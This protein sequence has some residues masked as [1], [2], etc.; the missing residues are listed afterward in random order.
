MP[1]DRPSLYLID[2]SSYIYRAFHA[3]PPLTSPRGVPTQAVYGFTTMLLKLLNDVEATYLAVIFDAPGKTFRD[4]LYDQYKANRAPAPD[5]LKAQIPMIHDVVDAFRICNIAEPG[6]EADDVIATLV[7]RHAEDM[8]CVIVTG[9]KDLMQLVRPS[10]RLW[11]TMRDRW[12]DENAVREKFGVAPAQVV[13]VMALMGDSI[14]NIPGVKGVGAK[15]ASALIEHFGD[16][17]SLL[18]RL[19]EVPELGLRGAKK[20]AERLRDEADKARISRELVVLDSNVDLEVD[21]EEMKVGEPDMDALRKIFTDLGFQSLIDQVA[22]T[23]PAPA[24]EVVEVAAA[25]EARRR[26]SD[27]FGRGAPVAVAALVGDGP[28]IST[29]ADQLLLFDGSASA[30]A[31]ALDRVDVAE[32]L[33]EILSESRARIVG[34]D[35][36]RM[37]HALALRGIDLPEASFDIMVASYVVDPTAAHGLEAIVSQHIGGAVSGYG[38][39]VD[40]T[41]SVLGQILEVEKSLRKQLADAEL[42]GLFADLET[43]LIGVLSRIEARGLTLDVDRLGDMGREFAGRLES[44]MEEIHAI[45]GHPFNINSPPQLRTVLFDE[46]GLSTRGV[47][48][49]K[50]GFSTDVDVLTRLAADHPLPAKILQYRALSKLK[51]TYI[52]ALPQAVNPVTGRLHTTL[53]QTVAATGRISSSDPNL[54]NIPIRGE[55]G[56]RIREAFTAPPGRVLIAGDYSQIEL[57]VLAHLSGDSVLREAFL[58]GQDIHTRTAAEVFGV[59]PGIVTSEMR[60]SAKVINFGILYGMGPQRLARD[61]GISLGEAK[62]YIESYFERYAGV[63]TFMDAVLEQA[64]ETGF[65]TTILGRRRPVPELLSGQRGVAQAAERVATNTPIQG[66]A[67]D[68][69]K[70]AMLHV[71]QRLTRSELDAFM[72]LQV[73]DELLVESSEKDLDQVIELVREEMGRAIELSVPLEV[74]VGSGATWAEAH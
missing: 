27:L 1:V 22:R 74:E 40:T 19:D 24:V 7:R 42:T 39:S 11:D 55:E 60:R 62:R 41:A 59:L 23:A 5:E 8:D 20:V 4:D 46:L 28:V 70:L 16:V 34:Y 49:G 21:L 56:R 6:V 48:K 66:S 57:R 2:G 73:H 38:E 9:D 67:A 72:I 50:T 15:T 68:I 45:A 44:L 64:R 26:L 35:L 58:E 3:L 36:K 47:K 53:H 14:D 30:V 17:E 65:V 63:R 32:T 52:D 33:A 61:L 37:G 29:A 18:A 25:D 69:I 31:C 51:S 71:D 13:D 12:V 10:V 43:P 54:Q